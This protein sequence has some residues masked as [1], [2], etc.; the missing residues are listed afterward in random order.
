[1]ETVD[2]SKMTPIQ[3]LERRRAE[4]LA[5]GGEERVARHHESGRLTA[6][7]RIDLLVDKGSWREIGLLALPEL[8]REA[9]SPGDAIVTGLAQVDGR[10]VCVVAIDATVLAG[11]TAPINMR[12]QN[13]VA[14]WAGKRGLPLI[15]LSDND[16]GRL[17]DLLGWRFS[18]VP[19]DFTTF[20]QSP[21][22]HP[23]T[24]RITAVLGPSFGDA[25]LHAAIADLVVMRSDAAIALSGPPVIKGAIGEEISNDE[26]GGPAVAHETSGSAHL[27]VDEEQEAI[28]AIKRFLTYMPEIGRAHV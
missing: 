15:F 21:A 5:M 20:L 22:G 13:R 6:R 7:E 12:K 14:E 23:S 4:A 1:M 26:L 17:P 2:Q 11:T 18:G 16:G 19:F 27:V 25:A 10:K 28:D 9:P 3:E 8:R 24:P